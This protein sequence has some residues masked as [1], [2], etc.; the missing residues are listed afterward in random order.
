MEIDLGAALGAEGAHSTQRLTLY[1]PN[2]DRLGNALADHDRWV[3]QARELLSDLGGG[4]TAF[5]PADGTWLDD[6]GKLLW[7][8]TRIVYCYIFPEQFRARIGALRDFLHRFG[9]DTNQGEVVVEFDGQF[10]RIRKYDSQTG[11]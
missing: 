6:N 10:F 4:A 8:Q 7:E 9:N 1:I 5:P 2:K 3:V 11:T